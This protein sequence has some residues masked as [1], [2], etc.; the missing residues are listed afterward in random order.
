MVCDNK[1][2]NIK[3]C[4]CS[5]PTCSRKGLCCECLH[6]HLLSKEVPACFFPPDAEKTYNRSMEYF[7]SLHKNK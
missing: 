6:Y 4:P 7:V 5:Y 3:R 1:V 2:K